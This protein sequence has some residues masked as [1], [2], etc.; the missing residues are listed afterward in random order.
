MNT[1][2]LPALGRFLLFPALLLLGACAATDNAPDESSTVPAETVAA[3]GDQADDQTGQTSLRAGFDASE[4]S[5]TARAQDDFFEHINAGW[6]AANEIP[7]DRSRYG[8]FNVVF[9]RTELQVRALIEA[10]AEQTRAGTGNAAQAQIGGAYLSFMDEANAEQAGLAPLEDLFMQVA[11]I[12]RHQDLPRLFGALQQLDVSLPV[13]YYVDGDAA[14]PTRSLAYFWQG[15]L[16]LPDRDY[17]LN[18]GEKFVDIRAKYLIHIENMYALA[19]WKNAKQEAGAI[20]ALEEA[21]AR[22]QWSRV[23]NR[24]RER[25]Y[26]NKVLINRHPQAEFWQALLAGG[27]FGV[28]ETVV[29]AQDDYFSALPEFVN[30]TP[31][32]SWKAYLRFRLLDSFAGYLTK[33]ISAESF[34]F[35]GKTLRGQQ[36]QRPRWKRG[37]ATVNAIMGEQVGKLYVA[38]HFPPSAKTKIADMVEGLRA[39]FAASIDELP[40]MAQ[41]TKAEARNK[42]D[43]FNKKVGYPDVWRDYSSLDISP[44]DLVSN[45]RA[46]RVLE[47]RRQIAKLSAPVDRTE[48]GMTPQTVNAYYRPTLN[49]IVFPAAILQPPFFD[50]TVDDAFNYGAIGAVIGHEF[51]HG[52]D[53][54]GRKFD[55]NG[56]LRDWWTEADAS[57]YSER[58]ARLVAQY[59][60]YQPLADVNINGKLTLGENIGDL[61]GLTMAYRAWQSAA[62]AA[63]GEAGAP[64]IDGFT[65]EQRFFIGYAHA[66]RG[67]YRDE[68]LRER[69]LSDPHS[70]GK[71]RVIGV[72]RNMD[73]FYE[74]FDV[75]PADKM[76]LPPDERVRIW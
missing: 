44:T 24:D 4:F 57:A 9:D 41:A 2:G 21:L 27:N 20:F 65:G 14:D 16:G 37:V 29:L 53:D 36:E 12:T 19:G 3:A 42:L 1:S 50:P 32:S 39:A 55:G 67:K 38:D 74:A 13:V 7:A 54:Q 61:A 63:W 30:A 58:A 22:R 60:A 75:Q 25:I 23:Q 73:A 45:V 43:A 71:Y 6:L 76:Y 10:A 18:D 31:L 46:G 35:R 34:D 26:T 8:I 59:D 49:E 68:A 64:V 28:L 69:L 52:F 15:G 56:V 62:A 51:S 70:P 11:G 5:S 40:W 33:A 48:W 72:L 17:Y 66:W 47:N